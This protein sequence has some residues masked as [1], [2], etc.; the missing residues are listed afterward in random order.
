[1]V[2]SVNVRVLGVTLL[3]DLT[4]DKHISNVCLAVFLSSAA[5]VCLSVC[6]SVGAPNIYTR[7]QV[8]PRMLGHQTC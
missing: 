7:V 1:V 2:S 4:M 5:T 3:S 6:L 8:E